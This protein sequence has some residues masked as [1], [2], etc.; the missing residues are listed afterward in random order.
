MA[1]A[2]P[3]LRL[4]VRICVVSCV[5]LWISGG[6]VGLFAFCSLCFPYL[7]V[8]MRVLVIP[9]WILWLWLPCS[10]CCCAPCALCGNHTRTH[11]RTQAVITRTP[12]PLHRQRPPSPRIVQTRYQPAASTP[13]T[14]CI[15]HQPRPKPCYL[16][17]HPADPQPTHLSQS[18]PSH[19]CPRLLGRDTHRPTPIRRPCVQREASC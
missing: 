4:G 1:G 14:T 9:F 12:A 2:A 18:Y 8:T 7:L 5:C 10:S 3:P 17:R 13:Y 16:A 19:P 6:D 15:R 11:A